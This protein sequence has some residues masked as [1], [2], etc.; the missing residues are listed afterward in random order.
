MVANRGPE[1]QAVCSTFVSMAFVAVVLR[2]YVRVR[3]VKA[4][5][6]DDAWMVSALLT[7]IMFATCAI[8]GIHYGTGRHMKELSEEAK[9]MAMR[10][11]W[12]CYVAYGLTMIAAKFSIALFLLRI[13]VHR[14]HRYII[15][16]NM[17]LTGITGTVFFFVTL[18]QCLPV[19]YF[20]N[21]N[22]PGSCVNVY[23][24]IGLTYLYS[25]ISAICDFTF[26]ILPVFLIWNLN[27]SRNSKI[28]LIPILSMGCVASTAVIVRM[29]FVMNFQSPDFLYDTVDIAIWSDTEQGLAI[30][31]GS[32]ATLRP[33]YRLISERLGL[34]T[35]STSPKGAS[36]R[37]SPDWYRTAS[38]NKRKR[39]G[40][41]SLLTLTRPDRSRQSD[42]EEYGICELP[43]IH[44]RNDLIED[45]AEERSAKGFQSWKIQVG[46]D[47]SQENLTK[48]MGGITRQTDVYLE[49]GHR[50]KS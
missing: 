45:S 48:V 18:F 29:A 43:P 21:K 15:Y 26:G 8:G 10:Y 23:V 14:V 24:I 17:A 38:T 41:F 4:F 2:I 6:W 13:T 34:S 36:G 9:Y 46:E 37:E 20:W 50:A 30:T 16:A 31:A 11:W 25:G 19:S 7:H 40:P 35:S 42:D 12:L 27:M 49:S 33:L 22:Q 39:S 44:L 5:G 3:I 28:I 47:G 1:L 32:L